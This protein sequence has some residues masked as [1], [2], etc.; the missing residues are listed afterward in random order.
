VHHAVLIPSPALYP[1]RSE[2]GLDRTGEAGEA[3]R[4]VRNAFAARGIAYDAALATLE[5]SVIYLNEGRTAD[6]RTLARE[7]APVFR[8]QGVHREALAAL[9]VFC[10]AAERE[11]ATAELAHRVLDYLLRGRYEE[12]L[13]SLRRL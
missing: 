12:G 10:E 1:E 2:A 5:L 4:Q 13:P 8:A 9:Q 6:V 7:M 3:F 11:E